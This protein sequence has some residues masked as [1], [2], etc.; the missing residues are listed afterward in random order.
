[1]H[2]VKRTLIEANQKFVDS[3]GKVWYYRETIT[4]LAPG[5]QLDVFFTFVSEEIEDILKLS[6]YEVDDHLTIVDKEH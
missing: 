3:E 4:F 2:K 6:Y 5:G 1:M